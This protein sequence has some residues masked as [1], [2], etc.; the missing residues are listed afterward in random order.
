MWCK[1]LMPRI[2]HRELRMRKW[3]IL[4]GVLVSALLIP[5]TYAPGQYVSS[6]TY[7]RYELLAPDRATPATIQTLSDGRV[8]IYV[9]NPRNDDIRVYLRA[10]RRQ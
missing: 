4:V 9:V 2:L 8:S 7:T 6:D 1:A 3:C 10:R 5:V